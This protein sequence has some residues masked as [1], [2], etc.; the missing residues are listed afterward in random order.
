MLVRRAAGVI[1]DERLGAG[2]NH[3]ASGV[4]A[5]AVRAAGA[6]GC[7]LRT[8]WLLPLFAAAGRKQPRVPAA[9]TL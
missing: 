2:G 9:H 8:P 4:A 5:G 1:I 3:G 7:A 6:R